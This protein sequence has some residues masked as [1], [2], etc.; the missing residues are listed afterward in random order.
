[1]QRKTSLAPRKNMSDDKTLKSLPVRSTRI[2]AVVSVTMVL[3]LLGVLG[4]IAVGVDT[5]VRQ[6]RESMGFVVVMQADSTEVNTSALA[7]RLS[8]EKYTQQVTVVSA[9][10]VLER[11]QA[12]VGPEEDIRSLLDGENP[13]TAEVDV[14]VTARYS[15]TDSL[16][17]IAKTVENLPG[18][19]SVRVSSDM[20]KSVQGSISNILI[21]LGASALIL[22]LI[23]IILVNNTVRLAI[24]SRRHS[25]YTMQLVGATAAFIR[26]PIV[27]QKVLDGM[28]AG[29]IAAGLLAA[30]LIWGETD[31]GNLRSLFGLAHSWWVLASLPLAGMVLCGVTSWLAV[32][33]YLR[34]SQDEL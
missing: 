34:R 15:H 18:V 27:L 6:I 14:K 26:R 1:M 30:L 3:L 28:I 20:I 12:L 9:Q 19:E 7:S 23:S 31:R 2:T 25:I 32:D 5:A 21:L 22:L 8:K 4:V 29:I 10:Q 17:K 33:K 11:W 16:D 13:F 24:F